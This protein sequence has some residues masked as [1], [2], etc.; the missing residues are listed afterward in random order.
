MLPRPYQKEAIDRITAALQIHDRVGAVMPTGSGKSL[1]ETCVIDNLCDSLKFNECVLVVCHITDVVEQLMDTFVKEGRYGKSAVRYTSRTKPRVTSKIVFATSQSV[2]SP[3]GM[4]YWHEDPMKKEVK[5][6]LIDEAHRIGTDGSST[7][8]DTLFPRAKVIGLSATPFRKN[9]FSFCQFDHVAYAID[10][11]SL[12]DAKYLT[13]PRLFEMKLEG[14]PEH[15]RFAS[16]F[17]IWE[18]KEKA[19]GLV[20]VVYLQSTQQAQE[21][22]LIFEERKVKVA[23]VDGS[24]PEPYCRDLYRRARAGEV[25]VIVNCRKLETGIDIPN[26]GAV[27]MPYQSKSVTSYLQ[28]VG[29]A[30]RPFG[31]KDFAHIYVSGSAPSIKEGQWSRL[32][33]DALQAKDPLDCVAN[34]VDDLEQLTE[35]SAPPERIAW[36]RSAIQA[37]ELLIGN[38]MRSVAELVAEKR[39]PQKYNRVIMD[40]VG[41]MGPVGHNDAITEQQIRALTGR[42]AFKDHDVVRLGSGEAEAILKALDSFYKRDPFILQSGPHAGKHISETPSMYRR[43]IKDPGNRALMNR[44]FAAGKPGARA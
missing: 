10:T 28:R 38:G 22:R 9:Q 40:V 11:Q 39:F 17:K 21:M 14:Q 37:C 31:G 6:L 15:E 36:T 26:I 1:V 41:R 5:Y 24:S 16:I 8:I 34:L 35:D 19:R 12:I 4:S 27:F 7:M 30:L 13:A 2:I 44:W 3:R 43:F 33:R 32:Q 25:E 42:H 18:E 29:R 20:S 23:F